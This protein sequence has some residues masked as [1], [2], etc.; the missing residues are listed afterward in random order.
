MQSHNTFKQQLLERALAR[1]IRVE[2]R[3]HGG[4]DAALIAVIDELASL[5]ELR[6]VCRLHPSGL[7][8]DCIC[9]GYPELVCYTNQEVFRLTNHHGSSVR[10]ML[11]GGE[12]AYLEQPL[13]WIHWLAEHGADEPLRELERDREWRR[14][15]EESL[16]HWAAA[17]PDSIR[18]LWRSSVAA[19]Q[20]YPVADLLGAFDD[21]S[22]PHASRVAQLC[23]W[24]GVSLERLPM[25]DVE[26]ASPAFRLLCEYPKRDL[27]R[28][29]VHWDSTRLARRGAFAALRVS[30]TIV[31]RDHNTVRAWM[32]GPFLIK[33]PPAPS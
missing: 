7:G 15:K 22:V 6:R 11:W 30:R 10:S 29:M 20:P 23:H 26:L 27:V 12:D 24:L 33:D 31:M 17:M 14:Q 28:V 8:F 19:E 16:E 13:A 9:R 25:S 32:Q 2:I 4:E 5:N 21:A 3:E 18:V 1:V